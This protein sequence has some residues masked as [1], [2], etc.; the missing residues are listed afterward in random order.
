MLEMLTYLLFY[1][2]QNAGLCVCLH[3][4]G[5]EIGTVP[6]VPVNPWISKTIAKVPIDFHNHNL[7]T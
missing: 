2:N 7:G 5:A 1:K 3:T 4:T 6:W